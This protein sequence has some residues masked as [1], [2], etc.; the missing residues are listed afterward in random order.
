L[1]ETDFTQKMSAMIEKMEPCAL[2]GSD[3]RFFP[4]NMYWQCVGDNC[5]VSGPNHDRDGEGWNRLMRRDQPKTKP[6]G[7]TVRV[8]I[9]MSVHSNGYM[10]ISWNRY[11]NGQTAASVHSKLPVV[12][13]TADIPIP[14]SPEVVGTVEAT[15]E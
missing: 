3:V 6:K 12:T 4:Y 8:R 15:S 7:E 1:S 11:S 14:Q 5:K 10:S 9:P 13:I 2:C